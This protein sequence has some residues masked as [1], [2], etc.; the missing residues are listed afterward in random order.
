MLPG[1]LK[2]GRDGILRSSL[3]FDTTERVLNV[4]LFLGVCVLGQECSSIQGMF[5]LLGSRPFHQDRTF[6]DHSAWL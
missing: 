3:V 6:P 2:G 4:L 1:F 5:S